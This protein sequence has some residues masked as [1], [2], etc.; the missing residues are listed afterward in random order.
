MSI[1]D[2]QRSS[3]PQPGG[4]FWDYNQELLRDEDLEVGP[5][6]TKQLHL[7]PLTRIVVT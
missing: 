4:M 3:E 7:Y 1:W 2:S 6:R 5:S